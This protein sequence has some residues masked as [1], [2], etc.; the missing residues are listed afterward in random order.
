MSPVGASLLVAL[1]GATGALARY[2]V[3][4]GLSQFATVPFP[5]ATFAVNVLGSLLIG[6]LAGGVQA[7]SAAHAGLIVGLLGG[8]T[9]F[10]SFSLETVRLV[11][12]GRGGV[13][14]TYAVA[15]LALCVAAAFTGLL[16]AR[17]VPW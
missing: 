6:I 4:V 17:S 8:F 16:L 2:W 15:S 13:A 11:E 9:T 1:G 5:A 7:G 10:S 3:G 14:I 12:A